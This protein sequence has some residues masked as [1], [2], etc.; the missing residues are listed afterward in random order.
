MTLEGNG[1]SAEN[2]A[3]QK[4]H[5]QCEFNI[6]L[7]ELRKIRVLRKLPFFE[8]QSNCTITLIQQGEGL[9]NSYSPSHIRTQLHHSSIRIR[10]AN[11]SQQ[12]EKSATSN[13]SDAPLLE[14]QRLYRCSVQ[15]EE[16]NRWINKASELLL[17]APLDFQTKLWNFGPWTSEDHV[18]PLSRGSLY[19]WMDLVFEQI[20]GAL[21]RSKSF[22]Q[23]YSHFQCDAA[24]LP[25]VLKPSSPGATAGPHYFKLENLKGLLCES[26][27]NPSATACC[28]CRT[29]LKSRIVP[30]I[31]IDKLQPLPLE[32]SISDP[33]ATSIRVLETLQLELGFAGDP[34]LLE[35]REF[36][37][38]NKI[39]GY[40]E[41]EKLE[42]AKNEFNS[43][44]RKLKKKQ[45]EPSAQ[46]PLLE[47]LVA[48][49]LREKVSGGGNR[50][51]KYCWYQL[52]N[53]VEIG[54]QLRMS[55]KL[56]SNLEIP[57]QCPRYYR[58]LV[59]K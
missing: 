51:P 18:F 19:L 44:L 14:E 25:Q 21:G 2:L 55:E 35:V 7:N 8:A 16:I 13:F 20:W 54:Q 40:R 45:L 41:K 50:A 22:A 38:L 57:D 3:L 23:I 49:D 59:A 24:V 58:G 56:L 5:W 9:S 26:C 37:K 11:V 17:M 36:L 39:N 47:E 1:N 33:I 31:P 32:A 28:S 15:D 10:Q 29:G 48:L 46:D 43:L 27:T 34:K 52:K 30:E 42:T 4:N 53:T 12:T 6:V